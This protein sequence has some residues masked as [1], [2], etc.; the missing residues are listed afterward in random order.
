MN[1]RAF[2]CAAAAAS[3]AARQEPALRV[4]V[5]GSTDRGA[6]GHGI[7]TVW[8]EI[9]AVRLVAVADDH[10]AGLK[11]QAAALKLDRAYADYREMLDKEKPHIVGIGPRW[12][13][14]HAEMF[15]AAAER[16]I[17]IYMEKPFCRTLEEADAMVTAAAR[18]KIKAAVAHQT[19]YSPRLAV[20]KKLLDDGAIG[21]VLELRGR[22]K[23]D[24]RGGGEDLWVLGSHVMNMIHA[25][26]G[27]PVSCQATVTEGGVPVDKRHVK[28]G[29]E[30]IGPLAGD[31]LQAMYRLEG[32]ATAYFN[33]TREAG[34]PNTRFGLQIFGSKGV[35]EIGMGWMPDV[36][37][38][39]D[40]SWSPGRTGASW[41]AVTSAGVEKPEPLKDGGL[42]AGNIAAVLDLI[43]AIDK[44]REPLCGAAAARTTV[45]MIAA[46]FE[47]HRT[48]RAVSIP[49]ETRK[50]PLTLL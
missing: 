47:S 49:L 39:E 16:G 23:E 26:G 32:G 25:L 20:V 46:V 7:D 37:L 18:H 15:L 42:H 33:S 40:P 29:A 3:V 24:K 41:K 28:E 38:L 45:E 13:D 10:P 14:R 22:G 8:G 30:G 19:R 44:N 5:I 11:K 34:A 21:R 12:L 2:L 50:N 36:R 6:Y 31:S 43:D 4:A 1:R 48:G 17:H 35:L 27:A 9:P